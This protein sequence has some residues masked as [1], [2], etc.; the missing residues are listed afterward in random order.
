[1]TSMADEGCMKRPCCGG[2][3]KYL[4]PRTEPS[5]FPS[6]SSS[7]SPSHSPS[8]KETAPAKRTNPSL[9]SEMRTLWPN[10]NCDDMVV[11]RE[12]GRTY[13]N[14]SHVVRVE[15]AVDCV[16]SFTNRG[17]GVVVVVVVL[18]LRVALSVQACS[19]INPCHVTCWRLLILHFELTSSPSF[20]QTH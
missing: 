19:R 14:D 6:G 8:L 15:A 12:L 13:E 3:S 4:S 16:Y 17:S 9:P 10:L 11:V 18:E 1:M 2:Q 7:S 5:F 20:D